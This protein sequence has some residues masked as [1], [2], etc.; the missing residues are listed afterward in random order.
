MEQP[1][2]LEEAV[3]VELEKQDIFPIIDVTGHLVFTKTWTEEKLKTEISEALTTLKGSGK[4][5]ASTGI[6][7]GVSEYL[8]REKDGFSGKKV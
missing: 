3:L 6:G 4:Y 8:K 5:E 7:R 1:K 2:N